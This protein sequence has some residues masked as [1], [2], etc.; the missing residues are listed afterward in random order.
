M[1]GER[2]QL[3]KI[4]RELGLAKKE[5]NKVFS[6][7]NFKDKDFGWGGIMLIIILFFMAFLMILA[8]FSVPQNSP[9]IPSNN[10]YP[11]GILYSTVRIKDFKQRK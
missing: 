6:Y 2:I 1:K 9:N 7:N 3:Y 11:S 10:T 5:I 8:L 4:G